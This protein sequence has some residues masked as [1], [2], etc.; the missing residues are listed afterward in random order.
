MPSG[1]GNLNRLIVVHTISILFRYPFKRRRF[2]SIDRLNGK[3]ILLRHGGNIDF[4]IP[5]ARRE[6]E[7]RGG[8]GLYQAVGTACQIFQGNLSVLRRNAVVN[9]RPAVAR[10]VGVDGLCKMGMPFVPKLGTVKAIQLEFCSLQWGAVRARRPVRLDKGE[11]ACLGDPCVEKAHQLFR[12]GAV[13]GWRS[14]IAG[15]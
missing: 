10:I 12:R 15:A 3:L 6:L 1:D 5:L 13:A 8:F 2:G 14:D 9:K 11:G 4:H 7:P